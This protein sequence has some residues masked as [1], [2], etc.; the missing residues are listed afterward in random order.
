M[1]PSCGPLAAGRA[2]DDVL[3]ADHGRESTRAVILPSTISRSPMSAAQPPAQSS[4]AQVTARPTSRVASRYSCQSAAT[5]GCGVQVAATRPR[6]ADRAGEDPQPVARLAAGAAGEAGRERVGGEAGV[7]R[8]GGARGRGVDRRHRLRVV[9]GRL[10]RGRPRC[11]RATPR[12]APSDRVTVHRDVE[13]RRLAEP[14]RGRGPVGRA[15]ARR[16]RRRSS[17]RCRT[18]PGP[19]KRPA[20]T[21]SVS[22]LV[23]V[24]GARSGL[25]AGVTPQR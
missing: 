20:M 2:D 4:A 12:G 16:A 15:P 23:S 3:L 11:R 5:L 6:R 1:N 10:A 8:L 24:A 18:W 9:V 19:R 17:R 21:S 22:T 25:D 7:R 14:D 13:R